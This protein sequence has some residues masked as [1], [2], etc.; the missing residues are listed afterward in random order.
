MNSGTSRLLN[1]MFVRMNVAAF[2]Y[3]LAMGATFPVL[4]RYVSDG[5]GQ[6]D[7][8]VGIALGAMAVGSVI[9]RPAIGG[10]G[11]RR[12]RRILI[13]SGGII[14][15]L[16]MAGHVGADSLAMLIILRVM[17]GIGQGALVVGATTM[18]VDQAPPDR[19]GEATS[20]VFVALHLGSGTGALLGEALLQ[21]RS[22][23]AVWIAC[24]VAMTASAVLATSLPPAVPDDGVHAEIGMFHPTAVLPGVILGLGTL[25]FIGFNAFV[26]LF[27]EDIGI[28]DVAPFFLATSLTI[29]LIRSFGARLPDRLGPRLGGSIAL[30]ILSTG[31]FIIG[32]AESALVLGIGSVILAAGNAVLL[33]SLVA[34]AVAGV[35][36]VQ[37]SRALGTYTLFLEFSGALGGVF[38]GVIAGFSSYGAAFITAAAVSLATL[39][40]LRLTL[41]V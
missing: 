29:V 36:A 6:G 20:Y 33:P 17:F 26:P 8:A 24:A 14:S 18:A 21:A 30:V 10:I 1:A 40:L 38:F 22:F 35:P 34:A 3:F 15:A 23:D 41:H 31:L 25:G 39:V 19:S 27:A 16:A 13:I 11:D 28:E 32:I 12:G 9:A 5:L 4:P 2:L 37:R 7:A